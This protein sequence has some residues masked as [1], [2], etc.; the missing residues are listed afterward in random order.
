MRVCEWL[1]LKVNTYRFTRVKVHTHSSVIYVAC[2]IDY[3]VSYTIVYLAFGTVG[4][5]SITKTAQYQ[6]QSISR[7]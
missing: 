5:A 6:R 4:I 1:F 2:L 3:V 7:A